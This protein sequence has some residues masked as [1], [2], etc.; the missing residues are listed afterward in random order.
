[1][2]LRRCIDVLPPRTVNC[3]M[4]WPPPDFLVVLPRDARNLY[5]GETD[6]H[7]G[8]SECFGTGLWR[9][10]PAR[11]SDLPSEMFLLARPYDTRDPLDIF[12]G[13]RALGV[14]GIERPQLE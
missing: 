5:F 13:K 10:R 9:I 8:S 11:K 2:K 3:T 12:E 4:T 7:S 6:L 1:M 14:V